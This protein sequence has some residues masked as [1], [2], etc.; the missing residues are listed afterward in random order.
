[1]AT[2]YIDFPDPDWI[3]IRQALA[4]ALLKQAPITIGGGAAF[5]EKNRDFR[6]VFDDIVPMAE[7]FGAGTITAD[8]DSIH[9]DPRPLGP[10][11]FRFE[12]D[13][14]GSA[15]ELLLFMMP[16]LFHGNFRSIL[17]LGGVTHSPF[18]CP[19]AFVKE[20]ILAALEQVGL[21][22]S[23]T[24]RRFG[25]HG[26]GG[27]AMES[28]IYPREQVPGAMF[29]GRA[30][31]SIAGAKIFISRLDTGLAE[32]EKEMIARSLGLGADRIAIIE[33]MES[34]GPGNGIQVFA[35]HRETPVVISRE[36]RLYND[37]GE[38]GFTEETLR[39]IIADLAGETRSL[40]EGRLPE[41]VFREVMPYCVMTGTEPPRSGESAGAA[42]TRELCGRLL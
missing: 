16:A 33:V 23:L 3:I 38:P 39:G 19:T 17:E 20:T 31:P 10:G 7:Q 42:M 11:T 4:L 1:M 37:K 30:A 28:R 13:R 24:L 32:V 6:P 18:S 41:P 9:F 22:G 14:L 26:S 27:G 12:S 21:Y 15:V 5:L 36:M 29:S 25:F 40:L 2:I 8:A 35:S 34:D